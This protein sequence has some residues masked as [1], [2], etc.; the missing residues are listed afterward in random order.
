MSRRSATP[1]PNGEPSPATRLEHYLRAH[2]CIPYEEN[3]PERE[4]PHIT[5]SIYGV[6]KTNE[7]FVRLTNG[8]V[9]FVAV[10]LSTLFAPAMA[11]R[12]FGMDVADA[13]VAFGL[14]EKLWEKHREELLRNSRP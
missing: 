6:P 3:M 2:A 13:Q 1:P 9:S 7:L 10:T 11:D 12:V 8:C 14:A 5:C 4:Y